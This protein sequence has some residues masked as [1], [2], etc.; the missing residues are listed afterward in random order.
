MLK[1]VFYDVSK[2]FKQLFMACN[3]DIE[4]DPRPFCQKTSIT[5]SQ[6][7]WQADV[8]PSSQISPCLRSARPAHSPPW[9]SGCI[10]GFLQTSRQQSTGLCQHPADWRPLAQRP[11]QT[12]AH[13][14]VRT[15]GSGGAEY[16][17]SFG[18]VIKCCRP[19]TQIRAFLK[20][21]KTE[22]PWPFK[23]T[24]KLIDLL[25]FLS[26]GNYFYRHLIIKIYC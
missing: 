7:C 12:R 17:D 14:E 23:P 22:T 2:V 8:H 1:H 4:S 26:I 21:K 24:L 3:C 6:S 9:W 5:A 10:D 18:K 25:Q 16:R 20:Q 13:Q 19:K 15:N 11:C